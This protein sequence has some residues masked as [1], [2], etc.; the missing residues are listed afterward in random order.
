MAL[1][2]LVCLPCMTMQY[3]LLEKIKLEFGSCPKLSGGVSTRP[4][5]AESVKHAWTYD[6]AKFAEQTKGQLPECVRN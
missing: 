5:R 3:N 4:Q 6:Y 1:E 2:H